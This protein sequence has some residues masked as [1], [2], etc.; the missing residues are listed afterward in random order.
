MEFHMNRLIKF[1]ALL[2]GIL[3]FLNVPTAY[4]DNVDSPVDLLKNAS[5]QVIAEL[6]KNRAELKQNPRQLKKLIIDLILPHIDSVTMAKLALGKN[7]R[8]A[9]KEQKK[10]FV[11]EF[12]KC[13]VKILLLLR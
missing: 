13:C 4:A 11:I 1:V 8:K 9:S 2:A 12:R 7:W 6:K 10:K 3:I 5:D